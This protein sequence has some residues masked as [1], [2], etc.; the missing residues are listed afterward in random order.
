MNSELEQRTRLF[1]VRVI[2]MAGVVS[3]AGWVGRRLADQFL[4]AGTSVGAHYAEAKGSRSDAEFVA[5]IDGALQELREVIYWMHLIVE[6]NLL[7]ASRISSLL[8][9]SNEICAMLTASSKTVKNRVKAAKK[10]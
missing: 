1:A 7:E 5:K 9:E 6:S 10:V 8:Q 2:R 4:R 3:E